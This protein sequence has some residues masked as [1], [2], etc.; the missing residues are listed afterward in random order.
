MTRR[1]GIVDLGTLT[2]SYEANYSRL[3]PTLGS[4]PNIKIPTATSV[5]NARTSLF[6][7]AT[8]SYAWQHR[9][10]SENLFCIDES[11]YV[12]FYTTQYTDAAS[13]KTA[14]SGVYLVYELAEPTTETATPYQT[15]QIVDNWGT[16][17][18]VVIAQNGV[19]VPVG[20]STIYPISLRDKLE[21]A[22]DLPDDEGDFVLSERTS[23]TQ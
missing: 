11:G 10:E 22:P 23:F 12:R 14:M 19:E 16:E 9:G 7:E 17:E 13:F 5:P 2:Y 4:I 6:R 20:H 18:F 8:S 3:S 21:A 1:Y 15:P